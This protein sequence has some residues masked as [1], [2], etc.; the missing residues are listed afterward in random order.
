MNY[1]KYV[2]AVVLIFA[3]ISCAGTGLRT[4]SIADNETIT[5]LFSVILYGTQEYESLNTIAFL[6]IE[7][8]GYEMIPYAPEF[9]YR[10]IRNVRDELA[11]E[12]A[13]HFISTQNPDFQNPQIRRILGV[14]GNTIGYELR[15]L[16]RIFVYGL[17]D[18]LQ[19]HYRPMGGGKIRISI[20]LDPWIEKKLMNDFDGRR[21]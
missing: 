20:A 16:Y 4:A 21:R 15:P 12:K 7:G 3:I 5:G 2:F 14:Q 18:V 1:L 8:D 11:V 10:V 9:N 17:S 6:D 19:I 13:L